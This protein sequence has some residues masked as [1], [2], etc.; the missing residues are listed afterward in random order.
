MAAGNYRGMDTNHPDIRYLFSREYLLQSDWYRQRLQVKQQ[1]E[2]DLWRS[3]VSSLQ[4][5]LALPSHADD[6]RRLAIVE[7]LEAAQAALSRVRQAAYLESL[8]GTIGADPLQAPRE[9]KATQKVGEKR[10]A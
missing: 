10:V 9:A 5:F 2:V 8:V 1:R 6:A 3:H 7:R 4:Q